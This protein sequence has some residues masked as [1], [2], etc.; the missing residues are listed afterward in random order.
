MHDWFV[1]LTLLTLGAAVLAW[2]CQRVRLSPIV[3]YLLLGVLVGPFQHHLF[4]DRDSVSALAELGVIL[5]MFFVGIEFHLGEMRSLLPLF[6]GGGSLQVLLTAMCGG[7]AAW[8]CGVPPMAAVVA[9]LMLAFSSTALVVKAFD[10]R[11]QADSQ[12]ARTGLA[13]LLLQDIAAILAVAL[14]PLATHAPSASDGGPSLTRA[15]AGQLGLLLVVLPLLFLGARHILPRL[16]DRAA[17]ARAPE[18]FSLLALGVCFSVALAAQLS[19]ASLA[20]GAFLGGLVLSGTPFAFQILADLSMLRNLA[21]AFFF[22]T[23]GMLVNA[24]FVVTHWPALLGALAA[25]LVLKTV[26]ATLALLTFRVPLGVA[27]GAGLALAQIG[28]FSLV[29]GRQAEAAGLLPPQAHQFLLALALGSLL[30]TPLLVGRSGAFGTWLASRGAESPSGAPAAS[31]VGGVRAIVVGYGPVGVTLTRILRDFGI[32]PVIIDLNIETIRKLAASG[33]RSVFGDAGRREILRAAGVAQASYLLVT[34]PDLAGRVAVVAMARILN[35]NIRI[36]TRA[37]Y[38]GERA[39]LEEAG[40]TAVSYE[41]AEVAVALAATLLRE[42]G[43]SEQ[44]MEREARR[45]RASIALRT[46]FT[47]ALPRAPGGPAQ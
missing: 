33:V 4:A 28:E 30:L 41:E 36:V 8:L 1:P 32:E 39:M 25:L 45:I 5:L 19:G 20:L 26:L 16:F 12:R 43:A 17:A 34:L 3:G 42:I 10:E 29:V 38:L 44:D 22:M 40:A 27:A 15:A 2:L 13:V 6:L 31:P 14:L 18:A 24:G 46:G 37:R 21:M 9:G 35:S 47:V 7:A 11:G 23:I